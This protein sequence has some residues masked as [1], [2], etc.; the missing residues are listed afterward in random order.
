[1]PKMEAIRLRISSEV[2]PPGSAVTLVMLPVLL[3]MLPALLVMLPVAASAEEE[4]AKVKR[5]AQRI[6]LKRVMSNSPND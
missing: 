2:R 1:M 3:V 4:T 6:D 5:D